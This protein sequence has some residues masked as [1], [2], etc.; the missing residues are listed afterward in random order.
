M[1]ATFRALRRPKTDPTPLPELVDDVTPIATHYRRNHYPYPRID[2][3]TW[4]LP[5]TGA[6]ERPLD[7]NLAALAALPPRE[8]TALLECAGHRR[9]EFSPPISGVQWSLGALSQ[10]QWGGVA[11]ASV[12]DLAGL[13]DDAVEVVFH[14]ADAGPFGELP[15]TH[16][17]SRSVPVAKAT[18]PDTLLATTMNGAPLPRIHGAPVRALV[19]GWYAM[20]SVKWLTGIEVVTEPFRGRVP[21]VGLP[22]PSGGRSRHRPADRRDA[23]ALPVRLARRR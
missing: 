6:V 11:L 22:V 9:T 16:T 1:N 14:G 15:G 18:H 17:F 3:A 23:R 8:A 2:L 10:A 13:R 5:V 19:P 20:D 21:G 4:H 7:L 12:L